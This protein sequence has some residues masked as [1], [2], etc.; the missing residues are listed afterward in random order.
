[1]TRLSQALNEGRARL[2]AS[3]IENPH[4]E[5]SL[6]LA[7]ALGVKREQVYL[8]EGSG[9]R[10]VQAADGSRAEA[11]LRYAGFLKRRLSGECA[12]YIL[13]R[14]EFWGLDFNVTPTV[15]VPRPD[16]ETLVEAA[17]T[18]LDN[19]GPRGKVARVLDLCTGSGAAAIALK[20]ERPETELW[21]TDCS[22]RAL[23]LAGKNA[24]RLLGGSAIRF[25][26]GDLFTALPPPL[27]FF[28]LITANAPYVPSAAI[29]ALS[30]EVR[31][32]PRIALDGGK[33]GLDLIRRIIKDAPRYL[34]P[35]G[36]LLLEA[37]PSQMKTIRGLLEA[38]GF[39]GVRI[40][41]DLSGA[42]RV[43]TGA[44]P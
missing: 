16:T 43:I 5:A 22:A 41:T 4:F 39:S 25:Y 19:A 30:P 36:F 2:A 6:L 29:S 15:L 24:R 27:P 37:D 3:G 31:R 33:D 26:R 21:A 12:A 23:E 28:S 32:E 34:E 38:R 18:I 42:G 35:S 17:L 20:H 10:E 1:M 11:L 40:I 7:H 44:L 14:K 13:G 9:R 8:L